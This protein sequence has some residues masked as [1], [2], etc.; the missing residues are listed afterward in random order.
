MNN[1][2]LYENFIREIDSL[3]LAKIIKQIRGSKYRKPVLEI[4]KL[5]KLGDLERAK[6]VK[7][8]LVA[9]TVSGS[10]EGGPKMV[11][12]KDYN[13]FVILDI[14]NLDP[15]LLRYLIFRTR[16][17]EFTK[18]VFV[19]PGG[20]GL[21]IIVEVDSEMKKHDLAWQQV[22]DFYEEQLDV[23]VENKG[24]KITRLCFMSH[25]PD[26][27]FN[28]ESSIYKVADSSIKKGKSLSKK[29]L[30]ATSEKSLKLADKGED[31]KVDY[32]Q[33]FATC[34]IAADNKLVYEQGNR[35]T[36]IYYLGL[37]C[38]AAE[39][40]F[41]V[42]I[43]ESN[44]AFDLSEEEIAETMKSA[45]GLPSI[46][47]VK[48]VVKISR[49]FP[50]VI[51]LQVYEKLPGLLKESC[52]PFRNR[53]QK[54]DVFL[55][56]ALGFLSGVLP[57]VS[58]MYRSRLCFPNLNVFVV[59]PPASGK[60]AHNLARHL[61]KAY[62]DELLEANEKRKSDYSEALKY[63]KLDLFRYEKGDLTEEPE[64]PTKPN[65][66][67]SSISTNIEPADLTGYLNRN[68]GS[69]MIFDSDAE[70][71][72]NILNHYQGEYSNLLENAFRH[73]YIIWGWKPDGTL[74]EVSQPK[75]SVCLSGTPHQ[76]TK[77]IPSF[78][79]G[80]LSTFMFYIFR[81]APVWQIIS[82]GSVRASLQNFYEE[83]S[84]DVLEM[85]HFLEA[86]PATFDL[87]EAQWKLLR[88]T[89]QKIFEETYH[90]YGTRALGIVRRMELNCFRMAMI[91]SAIRKF[92]E[93]D[94]VKELICKEDDFQAAILLAE[95]Y[96][97]HGLFAYEDLPE[98]PEKSFCVA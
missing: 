41:D 7:R 88:S 87:T 43:G 23:A 63:Y 47:T 62:D 27:Y 22:R 56:G 54:R 74:V 1:I 76:L 61:G 40:P 59:A 75:L 70:V 24:N 37:L 20:R 90:D 35:S 96:L 91:L 52:S 51:P 10:F 49:K 98:P 55:T 32:L 29:I 58:G 21:K 42:A 66:K 80:L 34:V 18:A 39:I 72:G 8:T 84:E 60:S 13:P 15:H 2:S 73:E 79:N 71:L 77:F 28:P 50:P 3:S 65:F 33:A 12:L 83:L 48:K 89:F 9:F 86:H 11:F 81:S 95:N 31:L 17:I 64:A 97:K 16:H 93:K 53:H 14:N 57:G 44:R 67:N 6:Q 4:R 30:D 69:G 46:E 85:I 36:Y 78:E 5:I 92:E 26:A 25:D 94:S 45:Y 82:S 38:N 19:S 68:D